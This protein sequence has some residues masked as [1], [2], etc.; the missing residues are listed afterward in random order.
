MTKSSHATSFCPLRG[1]YVPYLPKVYPRYLHHLFKANE[2]TGMTL[3]TIHNLYA[4][5]ERMRSYREKIMKD[6]I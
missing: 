4:M 3:A 1:L 6:E 5:I 2:M